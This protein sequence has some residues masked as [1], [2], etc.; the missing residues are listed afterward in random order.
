[1]SFKEK[2]SSLQRL[3]YT[4]IIEKRFQSV[5]FIER[6]FTIVSFIQSVQY[7]RFCCICTSNMADMSMGMQTP[8]K[9]VELEEDL[10]R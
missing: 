9:K 1:M 8:M 3:K 2:L 10:L 6:F 4:S 7:Q 5:S